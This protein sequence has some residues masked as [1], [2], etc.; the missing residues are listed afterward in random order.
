LIFEW[1]LLLEIQTN[2]KNW[3][4]KD[5]SIGV[6]NMFTIEPTTQATLINMKYW[7]VS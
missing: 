5:K 4:W 2:C 7:I 3:V 1:T 6:L